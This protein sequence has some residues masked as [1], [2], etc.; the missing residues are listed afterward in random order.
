[1]YFVD[2]R[3]CAEVVVGQF[4]ELFI[5]VDREL[6]QWVKAA[7]E[8]TLGHPGTIG[9]VAVEDFWATL[10]EALQESGRP[11]VEFHASL[12]SMPGET[13]TKCVAESVAGVSEQ[14]LSESS[15]VPSEFGER[16]VDSS[17]PGGEFRSPSSKPGKNLRRSCEGI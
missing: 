8:S 15:L 16:C 2:A 12:P 10:T 14:S 5:R 3:V 7:V 6:H 4:P 11:S 9:A 13:Q 1:M 17:V